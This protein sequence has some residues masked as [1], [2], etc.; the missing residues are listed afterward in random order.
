MWNRNW[1]GTLV[2]PTWL[3][4][5]TLRFRRSRIV[6]WGSYMRLIIAWSLT[7]KK[8]TTVVV[9]RWR[10]RRWCWWWW[11]QRWYND[12]TMTITMMALIMISTCALHIKSLTVGGYGQGDIDRSCMVPRLKFGM[13]RMIFRRLAVCLAIGLAV[14]LTSVV[15]YALTTKRKTRREKVCFPWKSL[16]SVAPGFVSMVV[17]HWPTGGGGRQLYIIHFLL[18]LLL[19]ALLNYLDENGRSHLTGQCIVSL[20]FLVLKHTHE[21]Q[22]HFDF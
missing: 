9:P 4:V 20:V 2:V 1:R 22:K 10:S 21:L 3:I 19:V 14:S 17:P 7:T 18:I 8:N 6:H 12:V 5:P 16:F 11:W 13:L 15:V